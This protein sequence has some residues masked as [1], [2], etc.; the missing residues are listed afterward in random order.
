MEGDPVSRPA[1]G[2]YSWIAQRLSAIY[3][4]LYIVFLV[5]TFVLAPVSGYEQWRAWLSSPLISI[6]MAVFALAIA[7]HAWIG[8]RDILMDYVHCLV[9][10]LALFAIVIGMLLLCFVW[11]LRSLVVVI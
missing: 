11:M 9:A 1:H 4:G 8:V 3:L 10:R 5:T 6:S 7:I 2:L